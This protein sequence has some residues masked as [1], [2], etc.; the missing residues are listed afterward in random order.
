VDDPQLISEK[1]AGGIQLPKRDRYDNSKATD[2]YQKFIDACKNTK[3]YPGS[4]EEAEHLTEAVNLYAAALRS[5]KLLKYDA[6]SMQITNAPE[7]NKY[8]NRE[9]RPG[10]DPAS[11]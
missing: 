11:I 10:W 5:G 3:Q 6:A 4:F 2:A 7:A 9:Y 8:L 1:Q